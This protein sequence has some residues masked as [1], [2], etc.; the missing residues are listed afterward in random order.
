VDNKEVLKNEEIKTEN[1]EN[2]EENQE[3]KNWVN[4]GNNIK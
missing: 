4:I 1:K 2:A 3:K